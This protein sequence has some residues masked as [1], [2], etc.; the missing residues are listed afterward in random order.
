MPQFDVAYFSSQIF[1]LAIC[2][3]IIYFLAKKL[4]MPRMSQIIDNRA[5][6]IEQLRL[7]TEKLNQKLEEINKKI[8]SVRKDSILQYSKI[9]A[10]AKLHSSKKRIDFIKQNQSQ[11]IEL[12]NKSN[13]FL[14]EIIK[15]YNNNS[16]SAINEL[17]KNISGQL[18]SKKLTK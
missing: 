9:I 15:D 11:I 3:T 12:Q 5:D 6:K 8:E 17:A 18:L 14:E 4:F 16:E 2:F 13:L 7:D 10:D 1:W